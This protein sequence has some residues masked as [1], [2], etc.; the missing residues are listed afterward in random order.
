MPNT[1]FKLAN[2][3]VYELYLCAFYHYYLIKCG[4]NKAIT[5]AIERKIMFKD[6]VLGTY[7]HLFHKFYHTFFI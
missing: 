2:D 6:W 1:V 3:G 7:I 5:Y 4:Q